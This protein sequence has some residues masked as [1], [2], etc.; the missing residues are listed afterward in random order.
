M[1]KLVLVLLAG[2]LLVPSE[3]LAEKY[4]S[5][6]VAPVPH[7]PR[8]PALYQIDVYVDYDTGDMA[9]TPGYNITNLQI[10]ITG[11][12]VTYLNTTVS[13]TAGQSYLDCLDYL[14]VGGYTLTLSTAS[15]IIDQYIITVVDD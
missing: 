11:S 1:K 14:S 8:T 7:H 10:T 13:L 5:K 4:N 15:G 12:G 3:A 2:M 6:R 9:I